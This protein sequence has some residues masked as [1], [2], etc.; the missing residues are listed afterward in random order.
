MAEHKSR[1]QELK[2]RVASERA[3]AKGKRV[4]F[5]AWVRQEAVALAATSAH[6]REQFAAD[7][8]IGATSLMR[9][10][11][12]PRSKGAKR[13]ERRFHKVSV[14]A[15]RPSAAD[16]IVL[17]FASGAKVTGLTIAQLRE[18]LGGQA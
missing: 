6:S 13:S 14:Q 17:T 16:G 15:P 7:M 5:S 2:A 9:W 4:R 10:A 12:A 1:E 8:G 11:A 3:A 18:L